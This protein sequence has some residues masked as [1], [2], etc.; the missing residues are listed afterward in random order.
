MKKSLIAL[1]ALMA[2]GV[3]SAQ[4]SV[5]V[6]GIVDAGVAHVSNKGTATVAGNSVTGLTTGG[7]GGGSRI[8]FRGVEDLGGGLKAGFWL[9]AGIANDSGAGSSNTSTDNVTATNVSN[10]LQFGRRATVSLLGNFG[11]ARLG[12]DF[13]PAYIS[14]TSFDPFGNNGVGA[15]VWYQV[16]AVGQTRLRA[17]NQVSY[18][19][20]ALGGVYGQLSYAIGEQ[21]SNAGTP[22]GAAKDDGR[23][24]GG[25]IGYAN[26]P[27]DVA[28]AANKLT[29]TYAGGTSND[30]TQAN[31]SGSYD[32]GVAKIIAVYDLQKAENQAGL[33]AP[34]IGTA[35]PAGVTGVDT[36][37]K[38]YLLAVTAPVGPGKIKA[39]YSQAKVDISNTSLDAKAKKFA[40]GYDYSFSKRTTAYATV[41]RIS[42][43]DGSAV[44]ILTS[45]GINGLSG[46]GAA[47]NGKSTGYEI[48][49]KHTF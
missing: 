19:L 23:T 8:G 41:A 3:A 25:R 4:S 48:G 28:L 22:A 21:A 20:P 26:G 13:T 49:L 24:I 32:F 12:R 37:V 38:G 33:T 16:N 7:G 1:A 43:S 17:S 31:I 39:A 45:P 34:A 14:E 15:A 18:I 47:A 46:P 11:E 29:A 40:I 44:G 30:R 35:L 42:N 2:A 6:F 5:T 27:V 10:A 36:K 9:E